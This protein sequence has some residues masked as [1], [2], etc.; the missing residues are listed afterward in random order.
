MKDISA[1]E[2]A[3]DTGELPAGA[4]G[5]SADPARTPAAAEQ[6]DA[7]K[8]RLLSL[9]D[10][11][12]RTIAYRETRRVLAGLE[13]DLGGADAL[14]TAERQLAQHAAALDVLFRKLGVE[15]AAGARFAAQRSPK[16]WRVRSARAPFGR[17]ACVSASTWSG[18][19]S[20]KPAS[21]S[22]AG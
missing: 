11:D 17:A 15:R 22:R 6:P 5:C 21:R 9:A 13:A 10:V 7:G 19:R 20:A 4:G 12:K 2:A 3:G 16:S 8:Y 14:S 18:R 1:D